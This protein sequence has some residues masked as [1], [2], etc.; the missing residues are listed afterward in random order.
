MAKKT[1]FYARV[2]DRTE[3]AEGWMDECQIRGDKYE[4][5]LVALHQLL[6]RDQ[7]SPALMKEFAYGIFCDG[8]LD[9]SNL[10]RLDDKSHKADMLISYAALNPYFKAIRWRDYQS[11]RVIQNR[12]MRYRRAKAVEDALSEQIAE[13]LGKKSE[14]PLVIVIGAGYLPVVR[15]FDASAECLED[16]DIV[17]CDTDIGVSKEILDELFRRQFYMDFLDDSKLMNGV[18][19]SVIQYRH[20][21]LEELYDSRKFLGKAD[22]VVLDG[23]LMHYPKANERQQVVQRAL[24]LLKPD[25]VLSCDLITK[26]PEMK[27]GREAFGIQP[28]DKLEKSVTSAKNKMLQICANINTTLSWKMDSERS[29]RPMAIHLEISAPVHDIDYRLA[30]G[31]TNLS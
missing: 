16:V 3:P 5:D 22:V 17:A 28:G 2:L 25:G 19:A 24:Y 6:M 8:N 9:V 31:L 7:T 4:G 12:I 27:E 1:K 21:T 29:L 20:C 15:R 11:W 23:V 10:C 26:F 18:G 13:K 14:K 30:T